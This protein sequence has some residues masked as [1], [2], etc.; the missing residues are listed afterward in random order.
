MGARLTEEPVSLRSTDRPAESSRLNL[1]PW[2]RHAIRTALHFGLD[3]VAIAVSYFIAYQLR[4]GWD[5]LISRFPIQGSLPTW[6]LY[7]RMLYAIVP[8]W[9]MIFWYS[10]KIY[11]TPWLANTDRFLQILKGCALGC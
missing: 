1:P 8:L 3:A 11:T 5:W 4:F 9:L 6:A 7:G 2:L 10:S